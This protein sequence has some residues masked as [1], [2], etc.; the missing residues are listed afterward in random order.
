MLQ[1]VNKEKASKTKT[2]AIC[3]TPYQVLNI[4][5]LFFHEKKWGEVD[6]Y[7]INRF[8][9]ADKLNKKL[10][11]VS[12][13]KNI[14]FVIPNPDIKNTKFNTLLK[15][16]FPKRYKSHYKID[17]W[18]IIKQNYNYIFY[19]DLEPFARIIEEYNPSIKTYVY[20]DGECS[21]HGNALMDCKPKLRQHIEK[22]FNLDVCKNNIQG[23][24]VNNKSISKSTISKNI[25]QL[26][27]FTDEFIELAKNVFEFKNSDQLKNHKYILMDYPMVRIKEYNGFDLYNFM[28]NLKGK[29]CLL[30]Y[31]PCSSQIPMENIDVDMLNN[32][33]E[34]ECIDEIGDNHVLIGYYSTSQLMP[35]ILMDKEPYVIFTYRLMTS[36]AGEYRFSSYEE[37]I[38]LVKN[39]YKN[40]NK[41]FIP[42]NENELLFI[43]KKIENEKMKLNLCK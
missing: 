6:L 5:N 33:W 29:E 31:H 17:N 10:R 35:K 11:N 30:R 39:K 43:I 23:L 32:S 16:I 34:L 28:A 38:N 7:L 40:K 25:F 20:D 41:V 1:S 15:I 42:S 4:L 36:K 26:P 2:A 37:L 3:N 8:S 24:Y 9:S 19:G 13:F 27:H 22:L 14:Y 21:Y 18:E 12:F